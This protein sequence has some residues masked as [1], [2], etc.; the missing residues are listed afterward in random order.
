MSAF[1]HEHVS[2]CN[3]PPGASRK[4]LWVICE[5]L[6]DWWANQ[7]HTKDFINK[8]HPAT[9]QQSSTH[10]HLSA[11][12]HVETHTS[13]KNTLTV[14]RRHLRLHQP[15]PPASTLRG[16][17]CDISSLVLSQSQQQYCGHFIR[18]QRAWVWV[19]GLLLGETALAEWKA[20][21]CWFFLW[22]F[23][24]FLNHCAFDEEA[25]YLMVRRK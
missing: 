18:E 13:Q 2:H 23:G 11:L 21:Q 25:G 5:L 9:N 4:G 7:S 12:I 20:S 17:T 10:A 22:T 6:F 15:T 14:T 24:L 3:P 8:R 16:I 1:T 19:T